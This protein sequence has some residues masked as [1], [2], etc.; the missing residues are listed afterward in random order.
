MARRIDDSTVFSDATGLASMNDQ[1]PVRLIIPKFNDGKLLITKISGGVRPNFQLMYSLG[2]DVFINAFNQRLSMWNLSGLYIPSMCDNGQDF[3]GEPAFVDLYRRF[4]IRNA[5]VP[6]DL[7]FNG[8]VLVGFFV[9]MKI[10]DYTQNG[11]DGFS[12]ETPFLG[13]MNNLLEDPDPIVVEDALA[14]GPDVQDPIREGEL[15]DN[16]QGTYFGDNPDMLTANQS[17]PL[18]FDPNYIG[19]QQSDPYWDIDHRAKRPTTG[20][21]SSHF[22]V[23]PSQEDLDYWEMQD[24]LNE[25]AELQAKKAAEQKI[26]S[27]TARRKLEAE[28]KPPLANTTSTGTSVQTGVSPQLGTSIAVAGILHEYNKKIQDGEN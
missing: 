20:G 24:E 13:R 27:N 15:A 19:S 3:R 8:I 12:W 26:R 22:S 10:G 1:K 6:L 4:N 5:D 17:R 18:E 16:R 14:F 21:N 23:G 11:I 7:A 9:E 28:N 25:A 2:A